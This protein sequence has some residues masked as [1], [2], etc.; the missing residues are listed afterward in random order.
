VSEILE[1]TN[2]QL[3]CGVDVGSSNVKVILV[4]ERALTVWTKAIPV[5]R[6]LQDGGPVTDALALVS[7]LEG[8][9]VEGWK[10]SGS[11]R[12][13]RAIA[14]TGVGEDGVPVSDDLTPLDFAI[15][16]FDRRAMSEA[17]QLRE[18][19]GSN[20][21]GGI[22]IDFSRTAAK[23]QWLREHRSTAMGA[24]RQWIALTDYSAAWWTQTPF[25]SETLAARTACYDVFGRNWMSEVLEQCGALPLPRVV[26]AGTIIGPVVVGPM[27]EA[28]AASRE[29]LVIAGGHDHPVA[30]TVV[31]R[32]NDRAMVDSLGTANLVYDEVNSMQPRTD[33]YIA[34]SVPA[35]GGRGISCLGVY[36]FAAPLEA[37]RVKDSGTTLRSFLAGESIPGKPAEAVAIERALERALR[38]GTVPAPSMNELR[39]TLES[40]CLYARRMRDAIRQ[41]GSPATPI[42]AVGGWARSDALLQLRASVFG[43]PVAS[44]DENELTALGAALIARDAAGRDASEPFARNI[45]I[46]QPRE[47]WQA[48]YEQYYPRY[49]ER[50]EEI[51]EPRVA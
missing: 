14:I 23:W 17:A 36:E 47:D 50:L 7:T 35:L 34:F 19:I 18:S 8:L 37:F 3:V 42:Y 41:V 33:P 32:L 13:I 5:P 48:T 20:V 45:R 6:V 28:G 1:S 15:P 9:I 10:A 26:P 24:A 11:G 40:G 4:D 25:M 21:R 29:T 27:I 44:V 51:M 16:W 22:D 31:R 2:F 38:P 30:A 39:A 46:V 43:E 12:P 49:R